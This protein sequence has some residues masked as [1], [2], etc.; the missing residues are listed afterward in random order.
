PPAAPS[1]PAASSPT[2]AGGGFG[3]IPSGEGRPNAGGGFGSVPVN[4]A[5]GGYAQGGGS[6]PASGSAGA[7]PQGPTGGQG[8]GFGGDGFDGGGYGPP[9]EGDKKKKMFLYIGIGCLAAIV[10]FCVGAY[11]VVS[12]L[13][14]KVEETVTETGDAMGQ[15]LMT[16]MARLPLALTLA[17]IAS[18]CRSDPS[19]DSA[20]NFFHPDVFPKVKDKVCKINEGTMDA[21]NDPTRTAISNLANGTPEDQALATTL[22]YEPANCFVFAIDKATIITC[23]DGANQTRIVHM[24]DIE[25]L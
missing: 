4:Q 6:Y 1:S 7:Y 25:G 10:L 11:F 9:P 22:A 16:E 12:M 2:P 21:I 14:T 24:A 17:N 13:A 8:G 3:S 5:G 19:G 18:T 20:A 15:N 23:R